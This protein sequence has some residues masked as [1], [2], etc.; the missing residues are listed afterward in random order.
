MK[1]IL[2]IRF[3]SIG[4]IVLCSP[5]VRCLKE[6]TDCQL[7]FLTK[8]GFNDIVQH[9]PHVD[10]VHL[11]KDNFQ[12]LIKELRKEQFDYIIDLHNN[13]RT[14]RIKFHLKVKSNAFN[15]L[16]WQKWLLVKFKINRLPDVHIVDRY[17]ACADEL[18]LINDGKGLDFHLPSGMRSAKEL[19][20]IDDSSYSAFVIGGQHS[21]KMLPKEKIFELLEKL[22]HRVILLGGPEDKEKGEW[23]ESKLPGKVINAAGNFKLLESVQILKQASVVISH[24]TGLM[25]IAAAFK[26]PILSVWG[27]T[28]PEFGMYPYMADEASSIYEVKNLSCRPCSKIGFEK[29]PKA[30]FNC[31]LQQ[32]TVAIAERANLLY[33]EKSF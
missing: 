28:V 20:Q 23:L 2:V 25:H 17:I 10:K 18:G 6:Q 32:D 12:E 4:D 9:N 29:C 21:T 22:D 27:N 19:L 14:S 24:D 3:S 30:H 7:H 31:M 26:K 11:L 15:K 16:N 13:L 1:K 8:A 5:V 33:R